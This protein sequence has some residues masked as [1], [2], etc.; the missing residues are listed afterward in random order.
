MHVVQVIIQWY[1]HLPPL[2]FTYLKKYLMFKFEVYWNF[3]LLHLNETLIVHFTRLKLEGYV[4]YFLF[5][6]HT[7]LGLHMFIFQQ[8]LYYSILR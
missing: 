8:N 7:R 4:W 2:L 1:P 6:S 5:D 3:F